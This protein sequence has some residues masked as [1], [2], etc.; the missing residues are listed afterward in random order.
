MY[1][2]QSGVATSQ[3]IGEFC[4]EWGIDTSPMIATF[5]PTGALSRKT[6]R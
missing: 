2:S 3:D 6:S 4:R 1:L 5:A